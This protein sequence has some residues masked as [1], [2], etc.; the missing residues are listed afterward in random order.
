MGNLGALPALDV[1][2]AAT[3]PNTLEEFAR[4]A[5]IKSQMQNQ[6]LQSQEIQQRQQQINDQQA[7][8]KAMQGWDPSS[9]DYDGLAKSVLANG[10]SAN[11]ATAIQQHGIKVKQDMQALDKGSLEAFESKKK[12]VGDL[13]SEHTD[14]PD[15][16]LQG[17]ALDKVNSAVN[18]KLIDPAH[19][20]QLQQKVQ[21]TSDPAQLHASI[22]QF[23][24][25]NLGAAAVAA[26]QKT[27]AET[28]KD[29]ASARASNAE[30]LMKEIEA[31]GLKALTPQSISD[32]VDR[33][34]PPNDLQSGGPNRLVKGQA[35]GALARGD[36]QG[37]K[38]A[39]EDGFQSALGVQK[40][41]A[42][43][44][45]PA[46]Q[47]AKVALAARTKRAEQ[48][49][50]QGDPAAAGKLLA[51]GSLTLSELKSR[52]TTP[53][54]IVQATNAAQKVNPA[55]NPQQAEAELGVAKSPANLAFF[56]SAKSL[57]DPGGTLDQLKA[58]GKNIPQG[59]FPVFNSFADIYKAQTGSGPIAKYAA[60][61]IGVADD[62]AKVTGGGA[63]TEGMQKFIM[64]LA[65]AKASPEQRD[66][67]IDGFRG[68]VHSQI[69]SRIGSNK[70]LQNMYGQEP[71]SPTTA[72]PTAAGAFS[73]DNMPEHK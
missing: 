44:T 16:Q 20:A 46:I 37:A 70:V 48:V 53:D 69:K 73:W 31:N 7:T 2:P 25:G 54:F 26:Q 12:A 22:D 58:A 30:A 45:N 33:V 1:R 9:G 18:N 63:G 49:I 71:V 3:P 72:S 32:A 47:N 43:Q 55:F 38:K 42:E 64:S 23:V 61:L 28:A 41:V 35:L 59:Q 67:T 24:K 6:Q 27:A 36:L 11:A 14:I 68:A 56:G 52:G 17:W 50:T 15:D 39:I 13:F 10:G 4:V 8:T 65:D 19:A 66:G 29:T 62:Y 21:Q 60:T 57:T 51:D 34:F 40:D 5:Q